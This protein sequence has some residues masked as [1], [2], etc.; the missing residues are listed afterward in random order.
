MSPVATRINDMPPAFLEHPAF[1]I[2]GL[3][4]QTSNAD[5]M[6]GTGRL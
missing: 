5:E 2:V 3:S 4:T 1:T 6:A